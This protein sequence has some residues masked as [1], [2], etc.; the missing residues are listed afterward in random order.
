VVEGTSLL[1]KHMG[2]NLY[3][4]F[5]SLR[6]RQKYKKPRKGLF[7]F[8]GTGARTAR[9]RDSKGLA[10]KPDRGLQDVGESLRL[11]ELVI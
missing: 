6:L 9:V 8:A 3:R 10:C 4:G 5:E 1:R 11:Q 2:L 7:C